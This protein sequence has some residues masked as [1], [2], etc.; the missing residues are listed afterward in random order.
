MTIEE[1]VPVSAPMQTCRCGRPAKRRGLCASCQNKIWRASRKERRNGGPVAVDMQ[2]LRWAAE[3]FGVTAEELIIERLLEPKLTFPE[4]YTELRDHCRLDDLQIADRLG[5][6]P[7]SLLRRCQHHGIQP[8]P[9]L[10]SISRQ[11]RYKREQ[12]SA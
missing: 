3:R 11:D 9:E 8:T 1:C 5:I 7:L 6:Q 4:L 10:A 2:A 12:K